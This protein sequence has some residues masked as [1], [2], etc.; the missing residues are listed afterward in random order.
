[1]AVDFNKIKDD[2]ISVGKEVSNTA[3]D[4]TD[5]AK[6][7]LDIRAKEDFLEKQ[8]ALLGKLYFE[9][10]MDDEDLADNENFKTIREARAQLE[11]LNGK[12]LDKKGAVV[13]E[14]CGE[15]QSASS[16]YCNNCGASLR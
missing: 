8:Y 16:N 6:T 9:E 7:K 5:L 1:M 3:K 11:E 4:A 2:I 10:H 12:V 13:C 14:N 15:K